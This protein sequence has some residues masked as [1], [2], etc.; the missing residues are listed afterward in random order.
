MNRGARASLLV[1]ALSIVLAALPAPRAGATEALQAVE[2]GSCIRPVLRTAAP[3]GVGSCP[4]VRPG[5][6]V[7]VPST[8]SG[9]TLNFVYR[10]RYGRYYVATA[11][12]C[13]L[14]EG[15]QKLWPE[16]YGPVVTDGAGKPF[17][18]FVF[19]AYKGNY[20]IGMILISKGIAP[21]AS[22][23][24]F[25]GP[26]GLTTS[27]SSRRVTIEHF[28]NSLGIGDAVPAR[29]G[30]ALGMPDPYM[31]FGIIP[32]FLGDSGGPV[33]DASNGRAIGY[34]TAIGVG[35]GVAN[36]SPYGGPVFIHRSA[37]Q[38]SY[39]QKYLKKTLTLRTA[40]HSASLL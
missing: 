5:A 9:C 6:Y 26:T 31:V 22:M 38:I 23:C 13:V 1:A 24:H 10:A 21:K 19:A 20:D 17:G 29:T 37:P 27:R 15:Q 32:S 39:V 11:G 40:S 34:I 30:I 12:H 14:N 16:G 25:G 7:F 36:G 2:D 18:R 4:G 3:V 8:R 33:L 28:G 35:F